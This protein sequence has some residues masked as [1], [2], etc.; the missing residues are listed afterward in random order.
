MR[1]Y[2]SP[3]ILACLCTIAV[4][5]AAQTAAS[6]ALGGQLERPHG[7]PA[8]TFLDLASPGK[9][10]T[11]P[12]I[13]PQGPV[14]RIVVEDYRV[15]VREPSQPLALSQ[16]LTMD[17]DEQERDVSEVVRE[18]SSETRT[19][20]AY[21]DGHIS[22]INTSFVY[23]GKPKGDAVRDR[24]TYDTAGHVTDY[25]RTR[26]SK[27]ENHYTNFRYDPKGRLIAVEYRQLAADALQSRTQYK[28]GEDGKHLEED[29]Y[30]DGGE[31]IWVWTRTFDDMGHV[32][33]ASVKNR[34]WKTKQWTAPIHVV[35]RYDAKGRLIEQATDPY[36]LEPDG[37]EQSIP[38]GKVSVVYDDTK[39]TRET[40]YTDGNERIG[41]IVQL[42]EGGATLRYSMTGN[43]APALQLSLECKYDSHGNWT[44]CLEWVTGAG[45]RTMKERWTR[46]IAYR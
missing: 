1:L 42:D 10:I 6:Y 7:P 35:F 33:E 2:N 17:F 31:L 45:Q 30:D 9:M 41:S 40:S 11:N 3:A 34:D 8:M 4:E 39:H 24:W 46:T 26:G 25:H 22:E 38:P 12:T 44:E 28:Y 20:L 27:S 36:K 13:L 37:S 14:A 15:K 43:D 21:Q 29:R 16:T 5:A 18:G 23:D 32:V 19:A